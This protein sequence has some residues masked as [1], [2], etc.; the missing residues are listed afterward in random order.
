MRNGSKGRRVVTALAPVLMGLAACAGPVAT[1][2][3]SAD[4]RALAEDRIRRVV[5]ELLENQAAG[6]VRTISGV[7]Y[8][9][10]PVAVVL[11]NGEVSLIPSTPDLE[12]S[13]AKI[14][15]QWHEGRRKPLPFEAFQA[16]FSR[17]TAQRVAVGRA[18]GESL[19]RFASTDE[20]GRFAFPD[21]PEGR[22]LVVADM[23]SPVSI[24]LWVVPVQVG[25]DDPRT[26][27]IDNNLLLEA[28]LP[29]QALPARQ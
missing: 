11:A 1:P 16:A 4:Q 12:S 13:L 5:N 25:T 26:F 29:E 22:W 15:R 23:S 7:G 10:A 19:V 6:R 21:V 24:L 3:P 27:L 18:R 20:K 8:V 28:R 14:Q 2:T 17:L 9:L